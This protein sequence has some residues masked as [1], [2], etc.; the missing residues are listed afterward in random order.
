MVEEAV[1]TRIKSSPSVGAKISLLIAALFVVAAAYQMVVP[2]SVVAGAGRFDCRSAIQ[3][4]RTELAKSTCGGAYQVAT[5]KAI[6]LGAAAVVTAV[7]G[8]LVFGV[9]RRE[10]QVRVRRYD[11]DL[12]TPDTDAET[13]PGTD[14]ADDPDEPGTTRSRRPR[15]D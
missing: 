6:A 13:D 8:F 2:Q 7:G 11:D 12:A 9:V 5:V 1:E 3:G 10:E 15:A 4:P 14:P